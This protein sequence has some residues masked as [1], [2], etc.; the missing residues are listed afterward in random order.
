MAVKPLKLGE[1]TNVFEMTVKDTDRIG[2]INRGDQFVAS[3]FN[4]FQMARGNI[5]ADSGDGKIFG[6]T[7]FRV[8]PISF[9]Q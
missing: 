4:S 2:R 1:E 3:V 5:A 8:L 7:F 9:F 6:H